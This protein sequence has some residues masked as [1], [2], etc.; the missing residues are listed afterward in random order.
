M[1][2][3]ALPASPYLNSAL[4]SSM[5]PGGRVISKPLPTGESP[6]S[7]CSS[8]AKHIQQSW[9]SPKLFSCPFGLCSY[10]CRGS[11]AV[12]CIVKENPSP[13]QN[14]TGC[15]SSKYM[16][17]AACPE[18]PP[19]RRSTN[20]QLYLCH[21]AWLE[22]PD[23]LIALCSVTSPLCPQSSSLTQPTRPEQTFLLI[24]VKAADTG[25]FIQ[26]NCV[27]LQSK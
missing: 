20:T 21:H 25:L 6:L 4:K 16:N 23:K 17:A 26:P 1:P 13:E 9:L 27:M 2:P 10:T 8:L 22:T 12:L 14:S 15:F 3:P 11:T 5:W 7:T 19:L 18:L 24:A